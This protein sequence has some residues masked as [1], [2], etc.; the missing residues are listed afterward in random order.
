M[1]SFRE[2]LDSRCNHPQP[3]FT[4]QIETK[5]SLGPS[6]VTK[7]WKTVVRPVVSSRRFGIHSLYHPQRILSCWQ[8]NFMCMHLPCSAPALTTYSAK[9]LWCPSLR[10]QQY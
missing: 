1:G 6:L 5:T 7:T 9:S 3:A 8:A 4:S 2:M 10:R